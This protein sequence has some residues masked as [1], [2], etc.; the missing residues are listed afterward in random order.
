MYALLQTPQEIELNALY[1]ERFFFCETDE[2]YEEKVALNDMKIASLMSSF[3][4]PKAEWLITVIRE[5]E[6]VL[7]GLIETRKRVQKRE[8]VAKNALEL[9]K[10][11][12]KDHMIAFKLD[13]ITSEL[14]G[15]LSI[16][17][18]VRVANIPA[19]FDCTQ[20]PDEYRKDTPAKSEAIKGKLNKAL[21]NGENI[22]E[23]ELL[24]SHKTMTLR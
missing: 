7:N 9:A 18:S 8:Q 17:N 22:C 3:V 4:G 19:D 13:K 10:E 24:P 23:L 14:G 2:D 1:D 21:R 15:S 20:L 16:G 11:R 12:A 5:K 6:I